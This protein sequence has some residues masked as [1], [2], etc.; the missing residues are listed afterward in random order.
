MKRLSWK[1]VAGLIDG[2]G[3]IDLQITYHKDYPGRP[4]I[5]PRLR[6]SMAEAAKPVLEIFNANFGGGLS[7]RP[8]KF[9]NPNWQDAWEWSLHGKSL[10]P[11]LQNLV[12]HLIVKKEQAKL[13]IWMIDNLMGKH[14]P[15]RV[16]ERL[17]EEMKAM[18]RDP[19]RL[20]EAAVIELEMMIDAMTED[21]VRAS[22]KLCKGCGKRM[23][24]HAKTE[25]HSS[26]KNITDA[27][28]GLTV[29]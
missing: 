9:D 19:H 8:R 18:K 29:G 13:L 5:S 25:Y 22:V 14:I 4:Y 17:K 23:Q 2:E 3:C 12:N 28:V 11:V 1:Y 10:R 27:I 24:R 16:R 21:E 26:C 15:D 6:V 20:S 7:K